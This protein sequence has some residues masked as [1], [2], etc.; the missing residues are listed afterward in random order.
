MRIL[1]LNRANIITRL[2]ESQRVGVDVVGDAG[3]PVVFVLGVRP[4]PVVTAIVRLLYGSFAAVLRHL[5]FEVRTTA[6]QCT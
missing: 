1:P 2:T 6:G 4:T 5:V 3:G